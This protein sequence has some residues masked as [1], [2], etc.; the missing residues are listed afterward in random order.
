LG[1][2]TGRGSRRIEKRRKIRDNGR[3]KPNVIGE[4]ARDPKDCSFELGLSSCGLF[5]IVKD[6][7]VASALAD[8]AFV[9]T[10]V[11]TDATVSREVFMGCG[12][13]GFSRRWVREC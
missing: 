3:S 1:T 4:R 9:G 13:S 12:G 6:V 10:R 5:D 11:P 7:T 8:P 2:A